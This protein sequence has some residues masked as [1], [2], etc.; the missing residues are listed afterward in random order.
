MLQDL[1]PGEMGNGRQMTGI[2]AGACLI[3]LGPKGTCSSQAGY[4]TLTSGPLHM[5]FSQRDGSQSEDH[6][7]V[8]ITLGSKLSSLFLLIVFIF[9]KSF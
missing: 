2:E 6:T 7:R 3:S 4:L 5:H 1:C 9:K 8:S